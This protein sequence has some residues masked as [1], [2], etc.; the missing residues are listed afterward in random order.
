[1]NMPASSSVVS[2]S[3]DRAAFENFYA[4]PV[5]VEINPEFTEVRVSEGGP[6]AWFAVI[7]RER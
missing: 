1:M 3:V 2:N 5:Q 4:G 7:R 6:K